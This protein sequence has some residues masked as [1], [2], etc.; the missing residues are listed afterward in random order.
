MAKCQAL[1]QSG[2]RCKRND[3]KNGF[4][5]IE[6]HQAQS[7]VCPNCKSIRVMYISGGN[8]Y[9]CRDCG[10]RWTK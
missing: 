4:C 10:H 6:S 8:R 9:R 3:I 5:A 1:T 2:E 7:N